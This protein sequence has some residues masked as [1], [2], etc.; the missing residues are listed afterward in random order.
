MIE[1]PPIPARP[2]ATVLLLRNGARGLEVFMVT[3]HLKSSFMAG[4]LV[5]PGG[6]VDPAD[7]DPEM[8]AA[9][10]RPADLDFRI[11]AIRE[12]FEEAGILLARPRG[13]TGLIGPD[14][15]AG[16]EKQYRVRLNRGE[17]GFPAL[18][19]A[20]ALVPAPDA[21]IGFAHWI[22]PENL[23]KRFDT[24]FYLARAPEGQLGLHDDGELTES[25]WVRP[26][27]ALTEAAAG[28][29][30][31]V[32]A[33]RLNLELLGQSDTVDGALAAAKRRQIV[34]VLPVIAPT[35]SGPVIRIPADSG[36][37][38]SEIPAEAY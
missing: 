24:R 13:A 5:F 14:R 19:T 29:C 20:E 38:V 7:S 21:L 22:T 12:T 23:P 27:E 34:T 15:L 1:T 18:L 9:L 32:L 33:T 37:G 36:Y 11:A 25:R 30:K 10:T 28:R 17:I 4:A 31:I 8:L 16:I 35:P 26:A 2:A 6:A 3:R